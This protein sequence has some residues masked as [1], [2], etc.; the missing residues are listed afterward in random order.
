MGLFD[1]LDPSSWLS[2]LGSGISDLFSGS[3]PTS[4]PSDAASAVSS[5]PGAGD[6]ATAGALPSFD[7]SALLGGATPDGGVAGPSPALA[8]LPSLNT[9]SPIGQ[10]TSLDSFA[11]ST[12]TPGVSNVSNLGIPAEGIKG[13][14]S[15]QATGAGSFLSQYGKYALPAAAVGMA[16]L[17][18]NQPLPGV[19]GMK[20]DVA[21][22][23][24]AAPG[25]MAPLTSGAPLP[26]AVGQSLMASRDAQIASIRGN[27]ARMGMSGSS[28]EEASIAAANQQYA[29]QTF[30]QAQ[31]L[32][33]T[34]L[35]TLNQAD[36]VN[37]QIIGLGLQQ[38]AELTNALAS[39]AGGFAS[40]AAKS[41]FS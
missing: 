26:G 29:A 20:S 25:L 12:A 37:S 28:M 33:S 21:A 8:N 24:G 40:G 18:S 4:L 41:L 32:Y 35:Q 17:K 23:R 15:P 16:A 10:P 27:F 6:V 30:S 22:L 3:T 11:S 19:A 14:T 13:L 31:S 34:G 7:Y 2:S 9:P 36:T 1:S 5:L 39:V 38:D